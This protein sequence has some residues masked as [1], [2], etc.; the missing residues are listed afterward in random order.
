MF[1]FPRIL[2]VVAIVLS[3]GQASAQNGIETVLEEL[4]AVQANENAT[5]RELR[6]AVV[7]VRG[8]V[9]DF[10]ASDAAVSILLQEP[11]NGIDFS[12]FEQRLQAATQLASQ[13]P[14][15][16]VSNSDKISCLKG[17][18]PTPPSHRMMVQFST[19]SRG[20]LSGL[21]EM[22]EPVNSS[23]EVEQFLN[24]FT[25][26]KECEPFDTDASEV[27]FRLSTTSDGGMSLV[28]LKV[29]LDSES[30]SGVAESLST[31]DVLPM[32][33][34]EAESQMDL[35]R[36]AIRDI[37]A[38][39][40]VLGHDPNGVDGKIG[41]GTRAA[42]RAWQVSI[43]T[44]PTGYLNQPQY[45]ALQTQ[46]QA[47]LDQWLLDEDNAESYVQPPILEIGPGNLAGTWRYSSN[48]GARSKLGRIRFTGTLNISHVGGNNYGGTLV[49][50]LGNRG[51]TKATIRGRSISAETNFGLLLGKV[52]FS[53]RVDENALII[54]GRDS[55]GCSLYASK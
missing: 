29:P 49:N 4:R 8:I 17:K 53:G 44:E 48:C 31:L 15:P 14:E 45:A 5:E 39:L 28:A 41:R 10:P 51:R 25:A 9:N 50:S 23:T 42:M 46:S 2:A 11:Y 7:K 6:D 52:R 26:V 19:D 13:V 37:Q 34:E 43:G 24:L 18:M 22:V 20:K 27:T 55:N 40:L 54:R 16:N 30:S 47:A 3:G 12:S 38:R 36:R 33:T 1:V 21:P 35:D 32:G